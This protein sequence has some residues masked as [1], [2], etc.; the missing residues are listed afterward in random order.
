MP[1]KKVYIP[2]GNRVL[3]EAPALLT[4]ARGDTKL[5]GIV[6]PEGSAERIMQ[7]Q[8]NPYIEVKILAVGPECKDV[9][10]GD[11]AV[12]NRCHA[13]AMDFPGAKGIAILSETELFAIVREE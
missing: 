12:I 8:E 13:S 11:T 5:G 1:K 2:T 4:N 9:K 10:A 3:F 7:S 6:L